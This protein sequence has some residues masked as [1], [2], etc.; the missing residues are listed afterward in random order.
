MAAPKVF[1]SYAHD[2][3]H[4]A[5]ELTQAFSN[6]GITVWADFKDLRPGDQW[7][8]KLDQAVKASNLF[9]FLISPNVQ[10]SP[11]QEL[12]S[13]T[14]LAK[15][16]T[17]SK[18]KVLPVLTGS[19]EPPPFLRNWVSLKVDPEDEPL[20]WTKRVVEAVQSDRSPNVRALPAKSKRER[21]KR[22]NEIRLAAKALA[23]EPARSFSTAAGR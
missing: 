7:R 6:E 16:W 9:L 2:S 17:N 4:L 20:T 15:A 14:A 18:T 19:S 12:E 1:I 13:Q 21:A 22:L 10:M 3:K 23:S 11:W 5:E 8:M